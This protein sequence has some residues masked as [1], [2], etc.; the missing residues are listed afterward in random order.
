MPD[1]LHVTAHIVS[2]WRVRQQTLFGEMVRGRLPRAVGGR[3]TSAATMEAAI[4][5]SVTREDILRAL[6][7]STTSSR[8][9]LEARG[10]TV[11]RGEIGRLELK[12]GERI[13]RLCTEMGLGG[14]ERTENRRRTRPFNRVDMWVVRK[15]AVRNEG[16][17]SI[18]RLQ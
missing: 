3:T 13:G 14:E 10:E 9:L 7:H 2:T 4:P 16:T 12:R 15:E 5:G 1:L 6:G 11:G 8:V 18:M 17:G